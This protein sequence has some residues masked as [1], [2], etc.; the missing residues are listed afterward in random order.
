[1]KRIPSFLLAVV[2]LFSCK[3]KDKHL[4]PNKQVDEGTVKGDAYVSQDIGWTIA[5]PKGWAVVSLDQTEADERKI[6]LDG[7]R[8]D[9]AGVDKSGEKHLISF[10]KDKFNSL[11]STSEPFLSDSAGAFDDSCAAINKMIYDAYVSQGIRC[12]TSS[13]LEMIQGRQ[14]HMFHAK[15]YDGGGKVILQQLLYSRLINKKDF[16]LTINYNNEEDKKVMMDA[17][18]NSTFKE[19]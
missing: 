5:I 4:G 6:K 11:M 15:V 9:Y 14:F 7:N 1:M 18:T 10:R 13:G 17:F 12:D 3:Q 8:H 16:S 2:L 19:D